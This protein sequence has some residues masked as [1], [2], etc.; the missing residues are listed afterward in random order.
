MLMMTEMTRQLFGDR[1][2]QKNNVLHPQGGE[3]K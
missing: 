1:L 2:A 3:K